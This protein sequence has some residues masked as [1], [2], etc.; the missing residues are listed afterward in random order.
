M[1]TIMYNS[2]PISWQDLLDSDLPSGTVER[3]RQRFN[4]DLSTTQS[5]TCQSLHSSQI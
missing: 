4:A 3:R 1:A 2:C 5:T